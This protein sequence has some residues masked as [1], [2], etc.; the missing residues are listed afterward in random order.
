MAAPDDQALD[1]ACA[2]LATR[3]PVLAAA[4]AAIGRPVWRTADP[5]YETLARAITYQQIS[6]KAASTIWHRVVDQFSGSVCAGPVLATGDETLQA[7]GLSR[8]KVRY[9]KTIAEAVET[10][11]LCFD[12]LQAAD[13]GEA[14]T[15]LLAVTGIGTWTADVFLMNAIGKLDAFPHGDIGLIEA[16]RQLSGS[17]KRHDLKA[18][19][20][21]AE[22]WRPYRGVAAHLL[23]GW[24]NMM[25]NA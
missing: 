12:R 10:G 13:I 11:T 6:T 1:Q 25:R 23:Y 19:S 5:S 18:F 22:A 16:H 24:L 4:Y 17:E 7:C 8:P 3:D 20:S 21:L 15:E 9:F 2:A 14:R